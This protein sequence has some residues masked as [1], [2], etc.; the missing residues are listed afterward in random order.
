M[1]EIRVK[2]EKELIEKLRSC[3]YY[4]NVKKLHFS[5][6]I[7]REQRAWQML[8]ANRGKYTQETLNKIFDT[9]DN[10][11]NGKAWYGQMLSTPN[12]NLIFGTKQQDLCEWIDELLFSGR[13]TGDIMNHCLKDKKVKGASKGLATLLL[14]LSDPEHFNVWVNSTEDGLLILGR[15][16]ELSG[17]WGTKYSQFNKAAMDFRKDY[18]LIPQ[19]TDWVLSYISRN[20]E[21]DDEGFL[22]AEDALTHPPEVSMDDSDDMDDIVGEKMDLGF[23]RWAPTN[24]M[25]VVALFSKYCKELGFPDIDVIRTRFP[26]AAVYEDIGNNKLQRRYVEFEFRS[27]RYKSHRKSKKKCHYVICWEHDWKDCPVQVIELKSELPKILK[28]NG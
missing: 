11:P 28:K 15:I 17:D 22:L 1:N 4:K 5:P 3:D 6:K 10:H 25:G 8:Q 14:Y 27:S 12:R 19:E 9:V 23:M 2:T 13:K 18:G 26:D 16:D 24:E 20:V 21:S 7:E